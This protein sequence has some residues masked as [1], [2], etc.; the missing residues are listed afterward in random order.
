MAGLMHNPRAKGKARYKPLA[1]INVTPFVDVMLVLL[2]VFMITAPLLIPGVRVDL[3]KSGAPNLPQDSKPLEI[4]I[5]QDGAIFIANTEVALDD[6]VPQLR[7]LTG[8]NTDLRIYVRGDRRLEYGSVMA[9]IGAIN[10]AGF[11]K[12]AL[13]SE[14]SE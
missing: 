10:A 13:L 6:L 12:V 7:V 2:V 14:K 3:P 11:K 9:V 5:R 8:S 1:E 4:A